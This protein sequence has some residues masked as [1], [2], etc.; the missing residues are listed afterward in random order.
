MPNSRELGFELIRLKNLIQRSFGES[1]W[2]ELGAL[3]DK[4]HLVEDHPRLLR[5]FRFGDDDYEGNILSVLRE[6]V[7]ADPA[8]LSIIQEFVAKRCPEDGENVS[9]TQTTGR[10]IVFAP[11][12][13][14][15]PERGIENDLVAVMMP[16]AGFGPVY[17]AIKLAVAGAELRCVRA[18]DIWENSILIQDVFSLIFRSH[19]VVCD[20]SGRNPNVMYEAGIAHTLGKHVVPVTQSADDIPFDLRHHRYLG[21]LNNGEG[22]TKLQHEL[23]ERLKTLKVAKTSLWL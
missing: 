2:V 21:Y 18:D 8:N 22:R 15:V 10:K 23:T 5:S 13:F 17:D 12:V 16:F 1:E 14:A 20:F 9:S 4:Q 19:I 6:I 7:N 3:T 11:S